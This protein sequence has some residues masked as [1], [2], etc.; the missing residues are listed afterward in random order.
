MNEEQILECETI[1]EGYLTI[2]RLIKTRAYDSADLVDEFNE[3]TLDNVE[4]RM[5]V[6][7]RSYKI[8]NNYWFHPR[9]IAISGVM[10]LMT[11]VSGNKRWIF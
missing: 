5:D 11:Y 1:A 7:R 10:L 4:E 8:E 6:I 3:L 9:T 2:I